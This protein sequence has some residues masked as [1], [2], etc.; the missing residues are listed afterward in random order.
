M[1]LTYEIL[2]D[3]EL[4]SCRDIC[5]ELMTFQKSKAYITPE[6]FDTMNFDTRMIPSI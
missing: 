3:E 2:H 6:R 4:E 1:N 5:N